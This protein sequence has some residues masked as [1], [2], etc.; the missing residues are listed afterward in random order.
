MSPPWN[1][2]S[3]VTHETVEPNPSLEY[4]LIDLPLI[5]LGGL[6]GSSHCIGMC[7][8]FA[9]SIGGTASSVRGN[10][11]RQ[12][13]YSTGRI[14]TYACG[15]AVAGYGGMRIADRA[16]DWINIP[17]C[18]AVLAGLL[19][20]WQGLVAAGVWPR[21]VMAASALPCM[22]GSLLATFLR[23]P[24][25]GHVFLAGL[26]TGLLPCGL[27][28]AYLALASSTGRMAFGMA[29][30]MAFGLGTVPL[31]VMTGVSGAFVSLAT[32]RHLLHVAAWCVVLTGVV[33]VARGLG[34]LH[35]DGVW[36]G[37]GCPHCRD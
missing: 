6:L 31:M 24:K 13:I 2:K 25:P 7:G 26:F 21:R 33:A 3:S 27:V 10:L 36:L 30:M 12:V 5:F 29:T 28:Y 37:T 20:I 14:F 23:S 11:S 9:L 19:L 15:G 18:L 32:R 1:W 16:N 4:P 35:V 34:F 17:A 22:S 8:G